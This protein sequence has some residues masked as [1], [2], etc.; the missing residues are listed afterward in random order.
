MLIKKLSDIPK[1]GGY[2]EAIVQTYIS[3]P[4]LIE[5]KKFDFRLYVLISSV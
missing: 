4:L 1:I 2:D 3:P 5:K